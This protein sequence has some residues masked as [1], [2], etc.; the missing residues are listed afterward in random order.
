MKNPV[1][2]VTGLNATDSPGPGVPILRSLKESSLNPR[3]IGFC[4]D[5]LEPGNFMDLVENS[6][7]L[8]YPN[9]GAQ[10]LLSRIQ[11]IHSQI[12][13]DVIMPCLD[14][15]LDNYIALQGELQKMGIQTFLPS[16]EQL[17]TRDK[18]VLK[19]KLENTNVLIPE[20]ITIQDTSAIKLAAEKLG[21]P[22]LVKGLFYEAYLA[23]SIEEAIGWFYRLAS[24]WGYPIILQKFIQGEECNVIALGHEGNTLGA[25]VMKKLFLTDKGKA[26]AGVT[27]DNA[28]AKKTSFE[29]LKFIGWNGGCELE[30]II[31]KGTGKMYLLEINPR[32]PA[33]VYLATASGMNLPEAQLQLSLG[34]KTNLPSSY[35]VGQ[36]FVRHSWDDIITL[37]QIENL[38][39]IGELK[40]K[41]NS[42]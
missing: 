13:I 38:S 23:Y 16:K 36:V 1:V 15:E 32:F 26:W 22:M 18:S 8:P 35:K 28:E 3:L 40:A 10:E 7:I 14:S 27:I 31:E 41:A 42:V 39:T 5:V 25:V 4:Y 34:Q 2:A 17:H 37:E 6:F 33:W 19:E 11:Y 9:T 29:I 30:Y 20:T 24:K 12:K 21:F